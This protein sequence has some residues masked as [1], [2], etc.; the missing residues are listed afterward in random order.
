MAGKGK[1][2]DQAPADRNAGVTRDNPVGKGVRRD[3][4][5]AKGV[6]SLDW[7]DEEAAAAAED[8]TTP[9]QG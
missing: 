9:P 7:Q 1:D 5:P 4:D 8:E 6:T 3:A 2:K